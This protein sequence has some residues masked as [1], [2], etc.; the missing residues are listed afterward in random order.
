L[1]EQIVKICLIERFPELSEYG[2]AAAYFPAYSNSRGEFHKL[3]VTLIT[4]VVKGSCTH[5]IG[6]GIYEQHG[7]SIGITPC[8]VPH[9]IITGKENIE[10]YNLYLNFDKLILPLLP[11]PLDDALLML[12][13]LNM[14]ANRIPRVNLTGRE[15]GIEAVSAMTREFYG[16]QAARNTAVCELFKLFL[17][18]ACRGVLTSGIQVAKADEAPGQFRIERVRRKLDRDFRDKI[19]L[20]Q[21]AE[22]AGLNRN[23]LC[24]AFRRYAG[25]TIFDYLLERRIQAAM[26]KLRQSN[27]KIISTAYEC[28]FRDLTH[29]NRTF[30]RIAGKTPFE[31]R[32]SFKN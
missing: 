28:G 22:L 17:I 27:E 26:L 7:P 2:L 14:A 21:L 8:G 10:V 32:Q 11:S 6:S 3:D 1:T 19:S 9:C 29:F 12:F 23:Y 4:V 25:K 13:P 16:K 18:G 5:Q 20:E 15:G 31:Y 24:R 30:K